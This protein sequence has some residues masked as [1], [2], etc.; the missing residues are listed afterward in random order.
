MAWPHRLTHRLIHNDNEHR[1]IRP[2]QSDI[3][4]SAL[5]NNT[6]VSLPTGLGALPAVAVS[7]LTYCGD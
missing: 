1:P 5:F 6:L 4:R 2:Y 3:V 7:I